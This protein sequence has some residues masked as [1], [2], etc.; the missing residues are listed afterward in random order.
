MNTPH[1]AAG[2]LPPS[3]ETLAAEYV[4]GVLD[5]DE[6]R[7]IQSR[8]ERDP[9]FASMVES[10]ERQFAPWH[11]DFTPVRA[12]LTAW[13]G[14]RTALGWSTPRQDGVWNSVRFWRAATALAAAAAIAGIAIGLRG[15][16]TPAPTGEEQ[17]ARPVTV[18]VRDD[19]T[20]G[21][22]A[23]IDLKA[24]KVHM[25]PVPSPKDAAGR[26]DELW[27]IPAGQ[28][29]ISLGFVS[30]EKAHSIAVPPAVRSALAVGATLAVTL[31]PEA[32]IPHAAPS[33]PVV[34]KGGIQ[35]I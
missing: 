33:G 19:G 3:D 11:A 9:R 23:S 24:G 27:V 25:V 16:P 10:W 1:D 32:G 34:A 18:L 28:K 26:V 7:A 2:D 17:A 22:I 5:A 29:P 31:E 12:P 13:P 15:V 6:R 35:T 8:L 14:I 20:T 30:N 21:W 4:L